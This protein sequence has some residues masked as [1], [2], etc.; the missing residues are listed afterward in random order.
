MANLVVVRFNL[1]TFFKW[2]AKKS[3]EDISEAKYPAESSSILTAETSKKCWFPSSKYPNI[4][5]AVFRFYVSF[6]G[7]YWDVHGT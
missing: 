6:L 5:A 4:Q 7:V 1:R 3:L 2:V